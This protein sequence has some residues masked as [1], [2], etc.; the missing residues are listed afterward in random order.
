[1]CL[2]GDPSERVEGAHN[3][4]QL[5]GL[6]TFADEIVYVHPSALQTL[7]FEY[8]LSSSRGMRCEDGLGVECACSAVIVRQRDI[9]VHGVLHDGTFTSPPAARVNALCCFA[10]FHIYATYRKGREIE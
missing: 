10:V 9:L 1:M 5:N 3:A 8:S 4:L 7:A 6:P 2:G